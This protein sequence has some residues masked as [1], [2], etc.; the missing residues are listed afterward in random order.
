MGV[1]QDLRVALLNNGRAES[2]VKKNRAVAIL[3]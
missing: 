3:I 2:F 1:C